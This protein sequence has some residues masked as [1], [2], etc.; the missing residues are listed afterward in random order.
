MT[1]ARFADADPDR[2]LMLRAEDAEDLKVLATL[3]QDAVLTA[4]D[5][6]W[7]RRS[8]RFV[9]L[10]S[11]FRWEDAGAARAEARP[12]ERVR[13]ILAVGDVM[14]VRHDGIDRGDRTTVLS[15][16]NI[17]W[18]P[19]QDGTGVVLLQFAGD[20]TIAIDV[21][22]LSLDLRDVAIPHVAIARELPAHD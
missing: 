10:I 13:A 2:P 19:G 6:T 1:D 21:E 4:G 20:G 16:L 18:Q 5:L 17:D 3:A 15:L 12:F 9:L 11:R 22:A 8:R 14:A 7:D